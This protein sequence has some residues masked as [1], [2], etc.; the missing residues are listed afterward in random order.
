[1]RRCF[2]N[3]LTVR[4]FWRDWHASFNLWIVRY[5]YIPM[6]GKANILYSLFP[7][8]LFIAMWHDPALHLIKWA[9]CIVVIFILELVVQQGYERVLAKPVRR[10]MSEGERAGG[11]TRPL[12]RWL[13]RLSAERRGQLYRLLRACGGAAILFGLIVANLIGFNIQPDFVHSKGDSQTDK[14]IFHAIKECDFLTWLMIGLCMFFPAVL[15]GIQRDWE[16]YR[17]RQKK[18]AYGLQ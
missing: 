5:M 12:A 2:S 3:T 18:K 4:D 7:I 8:F 13:S 15:S 14:S 11:L 10:A 16:Q 6:G 17:I 9:L 1:M